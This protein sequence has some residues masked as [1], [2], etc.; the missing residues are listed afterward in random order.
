MTI[1]NVVNKRTSNVIARRNDEAIPAMRLL[2][3]VYT[4]QSECARCEFREGAR[5]DNVLFAFITDCFRVYRL[6]YLVG[7]AASKSV[8]YFYACALC[9]K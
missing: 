1:G 8:A 3:G 2:R 6:K 7:P 5:N 4:E 9:H